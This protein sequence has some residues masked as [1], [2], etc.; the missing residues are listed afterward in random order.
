MGHVRLGTLPTSREWS[1]VVDLLES[2]ANV[3]EIADAVAEASERDFIAARGDPVLGHTTWLLTQ[4][5][6]VARSDNFAGELVA[7]GFSE[8]SQQSL[9]NVVAEFPS[10]VERHTGGASG[11]TDLGELARQ[12][13][14]ESL[15]TLVGQQLPTLFGTS[16]T[17]LKIELA[18]FAT[19]ARFAIL[20]RDFFS[21][22]TFKTLDYYVSRVLANHVGPGRALDSLERR[23]DFES[24]LRLHCR[25]ASLIVEQFAGGWF[26]K[27]EYER[28]LTPEAAQS[29]TDYALK[30]MREEL[31]M[32]RAND[33]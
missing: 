20:A 29:F 12:A 24:A 19:R 1:R 16:P 2:K 27:A 21:R 11:R 18:K 32:R 31:R 8:T 13:A 30:K 33:A 7:L 3:A 23:A 10:A 26:S 15:S 9:L 14:A 28:N 6:L 25:E 4:L 22:L 17:D 5:P